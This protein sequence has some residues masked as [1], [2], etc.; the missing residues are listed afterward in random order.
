M[1]YF[2]FCLVVII[3]CGCATTGEFVGRVRTPDGAVVYTFDGEIEAETKPPVISGGGFGIS[4]S[5]IIAALVGVVGGLGGEQVVKK[6]FGK[7][8]KKRKN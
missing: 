4:F 8:G 5:E 2:M 7:N 1:R 3:L 6:V